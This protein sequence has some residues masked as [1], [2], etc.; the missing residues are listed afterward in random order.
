MFKRGPG[1][2]AS[3]LI[4]TR[5]RKQ[6]LCEAIDSVYSLAK[7]K[8]LF[9]FVLKIDDDDVETIEVSE[10]LAK[11]L[12][13][14]T[15]ISP[16]GNGYYDMHHWVSDMC[17]LAEGDWLFLFNDDARMAT[18]EWDQILLNCQINPIAWHGISDI[19][20]LI[21]PTI[22]RPNAQEFFFLRK[23]VYDILGHIALSPH[24]DNWIYNVM[25]FLV[26]AFT[27]QIR[28]DHFSEKATDDIRKESKEAYAHTLPTLN[29]IEAIRNKV[30]DAQKLISYMEYYILE[31]K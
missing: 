16:R 12:P 19:C 29:S 5:G 14:K 24:N 22:T 27:I 23:K 9:E 31:N 4:P 10:R 8:T 18:N 7:D 30:V 26:S 3:I 20:L 15:K 25:H 2:L 11:V 1:P 21:A 13:I 17:D 28:I 6:W